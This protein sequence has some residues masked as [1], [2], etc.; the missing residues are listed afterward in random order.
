MANKQPNVK[1][2]VDSK[3]AELSK[4]QQTLQIVL[5]KSTLF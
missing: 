5:N 2:S 4:W 1:K 3:S